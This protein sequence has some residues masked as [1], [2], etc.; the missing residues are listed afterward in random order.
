MVNPYVKIVVQ[1]FWDTLLQVHS[2]G[3]VLP[4][5]EH[6]KLRLIRK[7]ATIVGQMLKQV[8]F[9]ITV[10]ATILIQGCLIRQTSIKCFGMKAKKHGNNFFKTY[11]ST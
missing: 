9:V 2:K 7:F 5:I 11:K 4:V 3:G 1:I 10:N 6:G 8:V